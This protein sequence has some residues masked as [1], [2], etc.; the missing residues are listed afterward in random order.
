MDRLAC[1]LLAMILLAP[2]LLALL[3]IVKTAA[4]VPRDPIEVRGDSVDG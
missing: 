1:M 2:S 3:G 4:A